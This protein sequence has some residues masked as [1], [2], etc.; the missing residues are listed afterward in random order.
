MTRKT[1]NKLD[2]LCKVFSKVH[3]TLYKIE[4]SIYVK[5][6]N[7]LVEFRMWLTRKENSFYE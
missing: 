3:K 4:N 7:L 5:R 2:K 6:S 1:W